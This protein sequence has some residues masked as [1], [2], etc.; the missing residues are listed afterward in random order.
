MSFEH[1]Y[2]YMSFEHS[3]MSFEHTYMSFEH[4]YTYMNFEHTYTYMS[5]EHTYTYM[6]F[7][8]TYIYMSFGDPSELSH[9]TVNKKETIIQSWSKAAKE[10]NDEWGK[11]NGCFIET[12][13]ESL[14][15]K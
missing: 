12:E 7:E 6:S 8:H 11:L 14:K 3:Y 2:T 13:R 4:T 9:S 10:V 5:F 1:T 15:Q